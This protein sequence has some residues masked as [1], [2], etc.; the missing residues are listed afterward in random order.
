MAPKTVLIADDDRDLVR[1]LSMRCRQLGARVIAAYDAMTALT[2]VHQE[3]PD[4]IILD[5][6]MPAGSG[7]SVCEMLAADGRFASIPIIVITGR[8]DEETI[9]RCQ[10]IHAHYVFKSGDVWDRL[11]PVLTR[12]LD[13]APAQTGAP[14]AVDLP[15]AAEQPVYSGDGKAERPGKTRK[16]S[17]ILYVE[18]DPQI[19]DGLKMRLESRGV[20]VLQA[21]S[22]MEGYRLAVSRQPDVILLD[23]LLPEGDG[24]YVLRRFQ[25]TIVTKAIPVIV[26]TGHGDR[27]MERKLRSQGAV[28]Y[29]TKPIDF[30]R[31]L[32]ELSRYVSF[33]MSETAGG[34]A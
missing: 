24:D 28:G 23:F 25:E 34:N 15:I 1:I 14:R 31:L 6:K 27:G 33:A 26:V 2:L 3:R 19:S 10:A 22:G 13:V 4:V 17:T 20:E 7:L 21:F 5:I 8:A 11:A 9:R 18:D 12:L 30:D 32:D 29:I 16:R